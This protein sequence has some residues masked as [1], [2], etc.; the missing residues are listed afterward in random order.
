MDVVWRTVVNSETAVDGGLERSGSG[1]SDAGDGVDDDGQ[2][3]SV[4]SSCGNPYVTSDLIE[5]HR[6]TR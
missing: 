4:M 2:G 5:R 1:R 6:A 3:R